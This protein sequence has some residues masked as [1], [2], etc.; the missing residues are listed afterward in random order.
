MLNKTR[1]RSLELWW[2]AKT[3]RGRS[4]G[5]FNPWVSPHC[6]EGCAGDTLL[7]RVQFCCVQGGDEEGLSSAHPHSAESECF[8]SYGDGGH[9]ESQVPLGQIKLI[10]LIGSF[11]FHGFENAEESSSKLHPATPAP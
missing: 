2:P 4:L 10:G 8:L 5:G 11:F 3:E 6:T 1:V 9:L 7:H